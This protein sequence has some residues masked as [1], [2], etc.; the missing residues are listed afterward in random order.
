MKENQYFNYLAE[1]LVHQLIPNTCIKNFIKNPA[2]IGAYA[3]NAVRSFVKG[4]VN[5]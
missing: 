4:I 2:V 1:E 3:E 5:L